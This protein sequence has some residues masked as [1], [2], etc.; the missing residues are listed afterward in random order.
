ML[1]PRVA[2][3]VREQGWNC[4]FVGDVGLGGRDDADV[5]AYAFRD[6]RY[7]L[8]TD[9][10]YWDDRTHPE[11]RCPGVF[12]LAGGSGDDD[13]LATALAV[14]FSIFGRY[15]KLYRR[16][17]VRIGAGGEITVKQRHLAT[18]AIAETR[19]LVKPG[20]LVFAWEP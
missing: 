4:K 16:M 12:I 7:L 10:G 14:M 2:E 5:A 19:Y 8:T 18:G 20:G 13:Q 9:L 1:G 15:P 6:E 3:F 17:K 11:H